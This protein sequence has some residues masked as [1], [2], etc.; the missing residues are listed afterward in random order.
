LVVSNTLLRKI[1]HRVFSLAIVEVRVFIVG[2]EGLLFIADVLSIE[3]R[4]VKT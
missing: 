2:S 1:E 4:A 3:V